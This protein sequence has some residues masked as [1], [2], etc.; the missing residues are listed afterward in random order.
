MDLCLMC[1]EEVDGPHLFLE[2]GGAGVGPFCGSECRGQWRHSVQGRPLPE[3]ISAL[4]AELRRSTQR[5][6][7]EERTMQEVKTMIELVSKTAEQN[8]R[9]VAST[10]V[11][12]RKRDQMTLKRALS[13]LFS[14]PGFAVLGIIGGF[15]IWLLAQRDTTKDA[16]REA[17][18]AGAAVN[19]L[20]GEVKI[21]DRSQN[22]TAGALRALTIGQTRVEDKLDRLLV[23]GG[24]RRQTP[25]KEEDN[26]P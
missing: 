14:P 21:L 23:G 24:S 19:A 25:R 13:W 18:E 4:E 26:T 20:N 12:M 2:E 17:R 22:E 7:R 6:V 3:R 8:R 10:L 9:E 16:V 5:R 1:S 15:A 11:E